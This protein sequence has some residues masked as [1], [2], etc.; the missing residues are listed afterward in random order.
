[1]TGRDEDEKLR[2]AAAVWFARMRAP[3]ADAHRQ[4][5]EAWRAVQAHA[6]AY[7]RLEQRFE[8]SA[9][10]GHSRLAQLR[11]T[12]SKSRRGQV[13]GRTITALAACLV[14][15]IA[16][17]VLAWRGQTDQTR[18]ATQIGQIRTIALAGGGAMTLDTDSVVTAKGKSGHRVLRLERGRARFVA[19]KAD[20]AVEAGQ[21]QVLGRET[22]FDLA[23]GPQEQL[24]VTVI[25]GAPRVGPAGGPGRK[26]RFEPLP[27]GRQTRLG[28]DLVRRQVQPASLSEANW[29]SGL[30]RFD[31]AP[32]SDVTAIANRYNTRKIRL[33]EPGLA[34]LRLSGVFRVTG[35]ES[36][37]KGLAAALGLELGVAPDGDLVLSR[38]AA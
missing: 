9:I 33:A 26:A 18:Y 8:E 20:L 27:A 16:L 17:G 31:Q 38:P 34:T 24:D 23:L 35:A 25:S 1:M 12:R 21:A 5:F 13:S 19:G 6:Q 7:A 30:R 29:P 10:L 37:A 36:L 11:L 22:S 28:P 32:L 3:G 14:A 2:Q 15:A 4:A